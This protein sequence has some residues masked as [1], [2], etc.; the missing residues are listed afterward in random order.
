[1]QLQQ[2]PRLQVLC[3][4]AR[5]HAH[6]GGLDD[7]RRRALNGHIERHTLAKAAEVEV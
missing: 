4:H 7:V 1:M 3:A 6:H 2:Q 5:V